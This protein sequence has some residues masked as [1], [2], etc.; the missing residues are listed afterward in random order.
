MA[1][2]SSV[3]P[4]PSPSPS[5]VLKFTSP[6]SD[7]L[8]PLSANVYGIDFL[9]FRI[10]DEDTHHVV[11]E[12]SKDASQPPPVYPDNFDLDQLRSI[13]YTFP[14]DFLRYKTVGAKLVF[15]VGNQEIRNFR[16]IERHYSCGRLMKSYDFNFNFC[17]PN[18]VNEWE[19]IYDMPRLSDR[20][21]QATASH[22][23]Q[24]DSFY[25]VENKLIMHNKAVYKYTNELN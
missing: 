11:F 1:S 12:V 25:F 13:A 9:S 23:S 6:C 4:A 5:D 2:S 20:E 17:I 7:F 3:R 24:S 16:M 21:I 8:C 10:R 14:T 22:G 19:A 15:R 18:S